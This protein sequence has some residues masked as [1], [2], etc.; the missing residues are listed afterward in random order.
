MV[1]KEVVTDCLS[2]LLGTYLLQIGDPCLSFLSDSVR[3]RQRIL[4]DPVDTISPLGV[5]FC[6]G[7]PETLPFD[8]DCIDVV[9]LA[10]ALEGTKN[11]R[12]ILEEAHRVLLPEGILLITGKIGV[13][14]RL[15]SLLNE[16]EFDIIGGKLFGFPSFLEKIGP[17]CCPFLAN[18]FALLAQKRC[19]T[20]TPVKPSWR[21]V[22]LWK[23]QWLNDAAKWSLKRDRKNES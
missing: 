2:G 8:R 7:M 16:Y 6:R 17:L 1:E 3:L 11:A 10:H 18:K 9:F 12:A 23:G 15:R 21:Q 20:L 14:G 22:D 4:L 13:P 19:I 5:A